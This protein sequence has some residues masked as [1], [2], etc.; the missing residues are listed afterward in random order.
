MT[1]PEDA[2]INEHGRSHSIG[3]R[4][5]RVQGNRRAP[6]MSHHDRFWHASLVEKL[7]HVLSETRNAEVGL[8]RD[9]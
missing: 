7:D 5:C 4:R 1:R 3:K 9:L 8:W 6:G 2:A